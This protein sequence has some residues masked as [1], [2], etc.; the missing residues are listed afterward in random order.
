[1]THGCR[2]QIS[3]PDNR[4]KILSKLR[5]RRLVARLHAYEYVIGNGKKIIGVFIL[6]PEK[7]ILEVFVSPLSEIDEVTEIIHVFKE[8]FPL[9]GVIVHVKM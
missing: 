1:M 4:I 6:R 5:E 2:F 3:L 7:C 8:S 9:K